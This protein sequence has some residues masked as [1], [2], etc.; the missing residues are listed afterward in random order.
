V[1]Q[2]HDEYYP[3]RILQVVEQY[4]GTHYGV[5]TE[6]GIRSIDSFPI[7]TTDDECHGLAGC[8][9]YLKSHAL[10]TIWFY[11]KPAGRSGGYAGISVPRVID[12]RE[13]WEAASFFE[14]PGCGRITD[15][16]SPP[17]AQSPRSSRFWPK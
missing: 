13:A 12:N 5:R 9:G 7:A 11:I 2:P 3:G 17:Q 16:G 6:G 8:W 14:I 1:T 4:D 10:V 15:E